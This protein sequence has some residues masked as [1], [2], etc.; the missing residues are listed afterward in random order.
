[1]TTKTIER[2]VD[3]YKNK[4]I[5][6]GLIQ[7]VP[8][9]IGAAV[10]VALVTIIENIREDR[11][12]EYY[13]RFAKDDVLLTPKIIESE[14]FVH[15]YISTTRAALNTRR[16]E[17]IHYFANLLISYVSSSEIHTIDEY[18]EYLSILDDMSYRELGILAVLSQ[19]EKE[20]DQADENGSDRSVHLWN[21]FSSEVCL[22]FSI[23]TGELSSIM[24]RLNRTGLYTTFTGYSSV[25]ENN[26]SYIGR[27]G[28][29][30][31]LYRKFEKLIRSKDDEFE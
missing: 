9:G 14:D 25:A 20:Y 13:D 6:R 26:L 3:R 28:E 15:A 18:E 4:P 5:L 17:K 23:P 31:P 11:A 22:M 29:L 2:L 12:R 10:D 8:F 21:R 7:L 24:T 30:T 1:M 27:I 16:R 19:Y